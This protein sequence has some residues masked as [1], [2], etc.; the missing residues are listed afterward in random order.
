M[1]MHCHFGHLCYHFSLIFGHFWS[2]WAEASLKVVWKFR[3]QSKITTKSYDK[4]QVLLSFLSASLFVRPVEKLF[5][6]G[7]K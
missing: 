7:I 3:N 2:F 6:S 1:G 5:H 4:I